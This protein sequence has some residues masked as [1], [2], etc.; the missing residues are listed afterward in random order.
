MKQLNFASGQVI[1]KEG[2]YATTMYEVSSGAVAIYGNHGKPNQVLLATLG[3]GEYFGEM[4]LAECYPRSATAV[5][6]GDTTVN[7]VDAEE[8]A[9]YFHDRPD[10]VLRIMRALS[11]RLRETDQRYLEAKQAVFDAIE[12]ERRG[13]KKSRTLA[14]RLSSMISFARRSV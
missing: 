10:V 12:A 5:A 14:E 11:E 1:F 3:A 2:E 4:G 7:E 9:S 13:R 6:Q 8:F